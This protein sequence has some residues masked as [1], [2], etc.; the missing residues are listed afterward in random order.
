MVPIFVIVFE[1]T[2]DS[3]PPPVT[4]VTVNVVFA[5]TCPYALVYKKFDGS[6]EWSIFDGEPS[7]MGHKLHL[8]YFFHL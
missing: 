8:V 6:N 3:K 5:G 7:L 1:F 4:Y 2:L